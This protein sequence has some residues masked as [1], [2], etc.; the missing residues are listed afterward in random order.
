M[1]SPSVNTSYMRFFFN[2]LRVFMFSIASMVFISGV[3]LMAF[4]CYEFLIVFIHLQTSNPH[5]TTMRVAIGLLSA[6]DMFLLSTVFFVFSVG[7]LVLFR[8]PAAELPVRLPE[9][10]RVKNFMQLKV[11]L[12][13]AILTTLVIACLTGLATRRMKGDEFSAV[14]LTLPG[15]IF[16]ISLSLYFLRKSE[17]H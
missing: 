1:N 12:W 10:L 6:I 5:E 17:S 4:A 2:I 8:D 14:L 16:L 15:I 11:I 13:E 7:L 3:I 9:W